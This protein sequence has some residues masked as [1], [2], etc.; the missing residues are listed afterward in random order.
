LDGFWSIE[1][2]DTKY[3]KLRFND[4]YE[5]PLI[6]VQ[7]WNKFKEWHDLPNNVEIELIY[8]GN[9]KFGIFSINDL[10]PQVHIPSFHSRSVHPT[11]TAYFDMQ[12]YPSNISA[13]KLVMISISVK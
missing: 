2:T 10:G 7:G 1:K 9:K 8:Y 6:C 5:N 11:K 4:D 3:H 13:A 12:L